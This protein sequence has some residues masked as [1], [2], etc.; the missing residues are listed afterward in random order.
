VTIL[1]HTSDQVHIRFTMADA[2]TDAHVQS[3]AGPSSNTRDVRASSSCPCCVILPDD[4]FLPASPSS[5]NN[6]TTITANNT[7]ILHNNSLVE[8]ERDILTPQ[9]A[10]QELLDSRSRR[11]RIQIVDTHCH[12]HLDR[13]SESELQQPSF[14]H[15]NVEAE[16]EAE[17]ENDSDSSPRSN[18]SPL[19]L[20]SLTC[21]VEPADWAAALDYAAQSPYR[22]AAIGI[23]PWYLGSPEYD[24]DHNHIDNNTDTDTDQPQYLKKLEQILRDHPHA[25][26][27]EIGLCKMARWTRQHAAGK[28][29]ALTIQRRV[30]VE[31][32]KLAAQYQ[33]PVT[34]HCVNQQGILLDVLRE[35][36]ATTASE[37]DNDADANTSSLPPAMALHSF[38]GT[39]HQVEQ[40]LKW[41]ASLSSLS[42]LRKQRQEPLLYFG[43]SHAV[44]CAMST[45]VK[46]RRQGQAAVCAV[47]ADRLLAES[48]L[49]RDADVLGG[50]VAAVAYLAWAL[51]ESVDAVAERTARNGLRF[52]RCLLD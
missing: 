47:P 34:I 37:S 22:V 16:D 2:D 48:D 6:T 43:F 23:H 15:C 4:L 25:A 42:P 33:R 18:K 28:Q 10:Y 3:L 38:S 30:F 21:A 36:A 27:G 13:V 41:E 12:A 44:N 26:V 46:S 45:S 19:Q 35:Q 52:L 8:D 24:H 11:R 32:L 20:V 14:Y 49:H 50:T 51:D 7:G 17:D 39:A 5:T 29:A 9:Q 40:L 31:Q 1:D